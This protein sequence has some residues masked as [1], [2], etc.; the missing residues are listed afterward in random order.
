MGKP[1]PPRKWLVLNSEV[2][3]S[4][5][6]IE[7]LTLTGSSL[8][9]AQACLLST[10]EGLCLQPQAKEVG[11]TASPLSLPGLAVE[12]PPEGALGIAG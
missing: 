7:T 4:S 2:L 6:S 10:V 8:G 5:P 12:Q 3:W 1:S 11:S 9:R